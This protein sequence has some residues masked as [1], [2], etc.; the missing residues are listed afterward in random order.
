VAGSDQRLGGAGAGG[1]V[2][3][4][5]AVNY[6]APIREDQKLTLSEIFAQLS[7]Q[8][9]FAKLTRVEIMRVDPATKHSTTIIKNVKKLLDGDLTDDMEL[10]D[11]DRIKVT[12]K[13]VRF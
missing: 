5:G 13:F 9:E 1:K 12:E 3:I 7:G 10:K 11:G 2:I 6:T 4:Y 8:T